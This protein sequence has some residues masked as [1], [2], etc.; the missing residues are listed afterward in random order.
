MKLHRIG[1]ALSVGL[2]LSANAYA[3]GY[4]T[5]MPTS[6]GVTSGLSVLDLSS[7]GVTLGSAGN[8]S[9][10][11]GPFLV[12]NGGTAAN[13]AFSVTGTGASYTVTINGCSDSGTLRPRLASNGVSDLVGNAGPSA[14]ADASTTITIDRVAPTV[15]WTTPVTGSTYTSST[16]ITVA[17]KKHDNSAGT[18]QTL[19]WS[20]GI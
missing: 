14:S 20:C 5:V 13:C 8:A 1:L 4:V 6:Y 9:A 3:D 17:I 19:Y 10:T 15:S 7:T 12:T 18:T 11:V 16:S 2:A